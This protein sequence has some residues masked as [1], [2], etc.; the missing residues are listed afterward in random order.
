MSGVELK[1]RETEPR[2]VI[3]G[4]H[5]Y[6]RHAEHGAQAGEVVSVGRAGFRCAHS[7]DGGGLDEVRWSDMLGHKA[8]RQRRFVLLDQGED[9]SIATDEDGRRVYVRG[10]LPQE[11]P[12]GKAHPAVAAALGG[13]DVAEATRVMAL[14]LARAQMEQAAVMAASLDRLAQIVA[15]QSARIDALVQALQPAAPSINGVN[16][17]G[18]VLQVDPP[19]GAGGPL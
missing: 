6:Y 16:D 4:D 15:A 10:Q 9:G 7:R 8:R 3:A 5:V 13:E 12:M 14:E 2:D 1:A 17:A 19:A 18:S 11:Q